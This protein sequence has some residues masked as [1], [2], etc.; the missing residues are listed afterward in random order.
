MIPHGA[1][2]QFSFDTDL[3]LPHFYPLIWNTLLL[4]I[5]LIPGGKLRRRILQATLY[6]YIE[7]RRKDFFVEPCK[8]LYLL[9][10]IFGHFIQI[11]MPNY[12]Q[13]LVALPPVEKLEH[14]SFGK[15]ILKS[16]SF[17]ACSYNHQKGKKSPDPCYGIPCT[18]QNTQSTR[19]LFGRHYRSSRSN[20]SLVLDSFGEGTR[21]MLRVLAMCL[22]ATRNL[23]IEKNP[24]FY[25]SYRKLKAGLKA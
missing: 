19:S 5:Y 12:F 7:L 4:P 1:I 16:A 6:V 20:T 14:Q 8:S 2:L 15:I 17:L 21:S 24:H 3:Q 10:S 18:L 9:L 25:F 22:D 11:V 13:T 23:C